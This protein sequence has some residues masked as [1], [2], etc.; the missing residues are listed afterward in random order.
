MP[1]SRQTL[2]IILS[3]HSELVEG[4][5]SGNAYLQ[6]KL[7]TTVLNCKQDSCGEMRGGHNRP[8]RLK[9]ILNLLEQTEVYVYNA[10]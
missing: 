8:R 10:Y 1:N 9:S 7:A 2:M 5:T 6:I 4:V 3:H